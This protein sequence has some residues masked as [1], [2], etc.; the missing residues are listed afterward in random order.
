MNNNLAKKIYLALGAIEIFKK[1]A[2]HEF[3]SF[4]NLPPLI[5]SVNALEDG[6][7]DIKNRLDALKNC[8]D[9][10]NP[11]TAL[12]DSLT[13]NL[14]NILNEINSKNALYN[15][16]EE[17]VFWEDLEKKILITLEKIEIIFREII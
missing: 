8:L 16:H 12:F 7:I 17:P 11:K 13:K 6:L 15:L 5:F 2:Y 4:Q 1:M 14:A 9:S 3:N 10:D